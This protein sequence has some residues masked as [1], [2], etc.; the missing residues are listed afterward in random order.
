MKKEVAAVLR[1]KKESTE[2]ALCVGIVIAL[3]WGLGISV[4]G[5]L[6]GSSAITW[7]VWFAQLLGGVVCAMVVPLLLVR[8]TEWV[9]AR[10]ETGRWPRRLPHS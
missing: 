9:T 1:I 4:K 6:L 3:L 7:E 8:G 5:F 10:I 2:S